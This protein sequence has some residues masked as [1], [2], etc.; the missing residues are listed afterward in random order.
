M[1][2][3]TKEGE[4]NRTLLKQFL[5]AIEIKLVLIRSKLF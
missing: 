2:K 4:M 1:T 5:N 3:S